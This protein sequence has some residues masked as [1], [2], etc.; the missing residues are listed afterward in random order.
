MEI[1][2]KDISNNNTSTEAALPPVIDTSDL[3][4]NHLDKDTTIDVS[5]NKKLKNI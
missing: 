3:D 4:L 1:E 5:G 2:I